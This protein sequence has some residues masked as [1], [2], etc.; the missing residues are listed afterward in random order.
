MRAG[1][2]SK[3]GA[4]DTEGEGLGESRP[5]AGLFFNFYHPKNVFQQEKYNSRVVKVKTIDLAQRRFGNKESVNG[6]E[7]AC[8]AFYH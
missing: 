7:C 5:S 2:S 3:R 4:S 8:E 1:P 6:V